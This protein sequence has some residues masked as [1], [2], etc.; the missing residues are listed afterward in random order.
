[1]N[2]CNQLKTDCANHQAPDVYLRLE[3]FLASQSHLNDLRPSIYGQANFIMHPF[4]VLTSSLY[5]AY[6]QKEFPSLLQVTAEIH[7][8]SPC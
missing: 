3:S 7:P 5:K 6:N 8:P 2:S 4:F 1:M